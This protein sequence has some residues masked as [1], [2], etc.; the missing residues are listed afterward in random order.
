VIHGQ[1][2]EEQTLKFCVTGMLL[3]RG[4]LMPGSRNQTGSHS[5]TR[6]R[7]GA[8]RP[9]RSSRT[10]VGTLSATPPARS[11]AVRKAIFARKDCLIS[12]FPLGHQ[13]GNQRVAAG[14]RGAWRRRGPA[15]SSRAKPPG[16]CA[17][18]VTPAVAGEPVARATSFWVTMA[19]IGVAMSGRAA[20]AADRSGTEAAQG[21]GWVGK[22]CKN[23]SKG[24]VARPQTTSPPP[25]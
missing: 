16:C 6:G 19:T 17:G 3:K 24:A 10:A 7:S 4:P 11:K 22:D 12:V 5:M 15:G 2:G 9:R 25:S 23:P 13:R 14:S 1:R 18:P 20:Q 8:L 21:T